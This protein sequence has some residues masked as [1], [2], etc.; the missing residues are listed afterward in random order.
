[1]MQRIQ[2]HLDNGLSMRKAADREGVSECAIRYWK[3][4]GKLK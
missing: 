4:K 2:Q 3:G 1:M